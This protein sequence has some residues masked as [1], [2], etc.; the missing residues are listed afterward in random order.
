VHDSIIINIGKGGVFD[1]VTIQGRY[2][3]CSEG[4][5]LQYQQNPHR[6]IIEPVYTPE[7]QE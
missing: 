3:R 6:R 2:T 5:G 4:K 1:A 7:V